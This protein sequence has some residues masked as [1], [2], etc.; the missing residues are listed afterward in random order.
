MA[1]CAI[2]IVKTVV[3]EWFHFFHLF[4]KLMSGGMILGVILVSFGDPGETLS[5]F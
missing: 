1:V 3:F 4:S 2:T 5:D